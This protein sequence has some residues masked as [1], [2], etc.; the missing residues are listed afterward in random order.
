MPSI[1][2]GSL[3]S[4]MFS[5]VD[6]SKRSISSIAGFTN[7]G[8]AR[9]AASWSVARSR[10]RNPLARRF[11]VV[12][13]PATNSRASMATSSSWVTRAPTSFAV[14]NCPRRSSPGSSRRASTRS[15]SA[16]LISD[17]ASS[18]AAL[19]SIEVSGSRTS[20]TDRDHSRSRSRSDPGRDRTSEITRR[21]MGRATSRTTSISPTRGSASRTSST[22]R[23]TVGRRASMARG[24][25]AGDARRRSRV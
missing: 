23:W 5:K 25:K 8:S 22:T 4:R 14:T 10:Q 6:G 20:A 7:S 11:V 3:V 12:S 24:P 16:R 13:W 15:I 21:G 1:S 9:I 2:R 19:P 17:M 18:A